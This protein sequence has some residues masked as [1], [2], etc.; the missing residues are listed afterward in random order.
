MAED[1]FEGT[2]RDIYLK[3]DNNETSIITPAEELRAPLHAVISEGKG[4]N[5]PFQ[6]E[7]IKLSRKGI[8]ITAFVD[9]PDGEGTILRLWEQAGN[10]G[11]CQIHLPEA[12]EYSSYQKCNLRGESITPMM[13]VTRNTI[14]IEIQKYE[15]VSFLLK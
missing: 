13:P 11:I 7:G 5:L 12:A 8:K 15:P 10:S 1:R 9:N 4:G 2:T 3:D 14:E 6:N